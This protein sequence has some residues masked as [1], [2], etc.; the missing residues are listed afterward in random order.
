ML[1]AKRGYNSGYTD[2]AYMPAMAN[3]QFR[4]YRYIWIIEYDVDYAGNWANFFTDA[5]RS[6]A[7]YIATTIVTRADSEIGSWW[8][9]FRAPP[10]RCAR[11]N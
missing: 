3:E 5:M 7:D 1:D 8:P 6:S 9:T 10:G 2:L 11:H 4:F